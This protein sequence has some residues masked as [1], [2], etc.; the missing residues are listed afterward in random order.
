LR[1]ERFGLISHGMVFQN[2]SRALLQTGFGWAGPHT[3][4]LLAGEIIGRCTGMSRM[5]RAAWPGLKEQLA[6]SDRRQCQQALKDNR[7]FALYSLPSS[8]L[9]TLAGSISLPLVVYVYGLNS[10]GSF[11][12]VWRALALP[13]VLITANVADAFHSRAARLLNENPSA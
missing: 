8:L 7:Q 12:L 6:L 10:G 1:K 3:V 4:G 9:D 2:A 13:A 11:A 5:L